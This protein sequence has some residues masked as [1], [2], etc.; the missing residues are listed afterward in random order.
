MNK[1][2]KGS[3][4][5]AVAADYLEKN[6]YVIL[7]MNYRCKIG[8]IDIVAQEEEE[9]VFIEVK[10]RSTLRLGEPLEAVNARKQAKIRKVCQYYL[11]EHNIDDMPIRFDVVGILE[12]EITLIKNAF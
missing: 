4:Y 7:C 11:M 2:E 1:R 5:E 6:G 10:Y 3:E 12:N 9:L 8:E